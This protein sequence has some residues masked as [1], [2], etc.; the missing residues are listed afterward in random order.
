MEHRRAHALAVLPALFGLVRRAEV[1]HR[2]EAEVTEDARVRLGQVVRTVGSEE[3]PPAHVAAVGRLVATEV[4]EIE[5]PLERE[6]TV[7][8]AG[9]G[10]VATVSTGRDTHVA[11]R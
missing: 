10:H 8:R 1:D 2:R 4:A 11:G 3:L 5:R 6:Q 9:S 7:G